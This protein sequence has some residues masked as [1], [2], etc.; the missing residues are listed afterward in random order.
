MPYRPLHITVGVAPAAGPEAACGTSDDV[1]LVKAALLYGDAV[2]L[3]SPAAALVGRLSEVAG[4]G[5]DVGARLDVL[6]ALAGDLDLGDG[7]ADLRR[8][9]AEVADVAGAAAERAWI[10]AAV[11]DHWAAAR[12][13]LDDVL[14]RAGHG[15]LR[16]AVE[17]GVLRVDGMGLSGLA[18]AADAATQA[19]AAFVSRVADAVATGRSVPM[20]DD[21]TV[22]VLRARDDL[23]AEVDEAGGAWGAQGGLAADWLSR[24]PLFDRATIAE[25]VDIRRELDRHLDGF[26]A[27]VL[28]FAGVLGMASWDA[29]FP[30]EAEVL[31]RSSVAPTVREIDEA[32]ASVGYLR[33]LT[34]RYAE[35]PQRFLPLAAPALAVSVA[36]PGWLVEALGVTLAASSAGANLAQAWVQARDARRALEEHRL[37]FYYASGRRLAGR[38]A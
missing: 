22:E 7:P 14:E 38:R 36:A 26:R 33:E 25:V 18:S 9:W 30:R 15:E 13:R 2:T 1:R 34:G 12:E 29:S 19:G 16:T 21:R 27:A 37:F 4:S 3:C 31:Y 8:A 28:E 10:T 20:L 17:A 11:D 6:V 32:V 24:L 35:A 23:L 5:P